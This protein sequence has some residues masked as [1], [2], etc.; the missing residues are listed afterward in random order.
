MAC[1]S[2]TFYFQAVG[3]LLSKMSPCRQQI[4]GSCFLIQS[5][6]LRLLMGSLSSFTFRVTIKRYEF[7]VIMI[8]I[9][10]L[11]LWIV[12]LDFLFILQSPP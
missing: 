4:D 3:V 11:F 9:Q 6:T 12:P 2:L 1:F 5:E 7:S 10:P 8:P